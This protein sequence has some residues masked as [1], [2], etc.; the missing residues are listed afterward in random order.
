MTSKPNNFSPALS[1]LQAF[2]KAGLLK[3]FISQVFV[4]LIS[5]LIGSLVVFALLRLLGGDVAYIL[6]GNEATQDQVNALRTE[7]GL[8]R[9][10]FV[11]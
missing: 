5:A 7:L 8:D 1:A 6:L 3:S 11:K 9:A 10:W 4:L 2:Q